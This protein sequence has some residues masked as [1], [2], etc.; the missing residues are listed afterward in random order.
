MSG[1]TKQQ[2]C[3]G[4]GMVNQLQGQLDP[5]VQTHPWT[6]WGFSSVLILRQALSNAIAKAT[7]SRPTPLLAC[8]L[9]HKDHHSVLVG[10][11]KITKFIFISL[12]RS[13]AVLRGEHFSKRSRSSKW[14]NWIRAH[15]FGERAELRRYALSYLR[16]PKSHKLSKHLTHPLMPGLMAGICCNSR[17]IEVYSRYFVWGMDPLSKQCIGTFLKS[18]YAK[19]FSN[20]FS[21]QNALT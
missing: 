9:K 5:A 13:C 10:S 16:S 17:R 12:L 8:L 1:K 3:T 19:I 4:C 20:T 14:W 18:V 6:S 2:R 11:A 15:M 7:S 21:D